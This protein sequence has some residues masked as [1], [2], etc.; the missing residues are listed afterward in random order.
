MRVNRLAVLGVLFLASLLVAQ[1]ALDNA[2]V[3]K[4][5]KAGLGDDVIVS[6]VQNQ[7]GHYA[8]TPDTLVRLK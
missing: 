7:P 6:M 5:A 4:M 2:A 1:Q 8:L 3:V